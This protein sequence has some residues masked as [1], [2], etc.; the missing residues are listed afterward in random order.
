MQEWLGQVNGQVIIHRLM[1]DSNQYGH[2][3][4]IQY[5]KT[6]G[7]IY[8]AKVVYDR[9]HHGLEAQAN[10]LLMEANQSAAPMLALGSNDYGHCLCLIDAVE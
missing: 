1:M 5:E 6:K 7:P 9:Q 10:E 8:R 3:L 4:V 2:C